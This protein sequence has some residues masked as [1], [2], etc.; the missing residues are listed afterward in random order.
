MQIL[1]VSLWS[2]MEVCKS[3]RGNRIILTASGMATAAP[4]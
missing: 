4:G 2:Y 1:M 3:L